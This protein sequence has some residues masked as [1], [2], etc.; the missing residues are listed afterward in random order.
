MILALDEVL[1]FL[2]EGYLL[3]REDGQTKIFE[4]TIKKRVLFSPSAS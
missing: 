2:A 4:T 1:M 3:A